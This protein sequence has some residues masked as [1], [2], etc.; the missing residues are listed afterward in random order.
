VAGRHNGLAQKGF[1]LSEQIVTAAHDAKEPGQ[2]RVLRDAIDRPCRPDRSV[3]NRAY[4]S[5]GS[6]GELGYHQLFVAVRPAERIGHGD[7]LPARGTLRLVWKGRPPEFA[8]GLGMRRSGKQERKGEEERL[9]TER[10]KGI[11]S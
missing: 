7:R 2:R 3:A 8:W 6:I 9:E 4:P 5:G 11:T 10:S 1:V